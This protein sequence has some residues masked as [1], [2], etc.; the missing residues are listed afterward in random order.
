MARGE[1]YDVRAQ[2]LQALLEKVEEDQFPSSTML[3][4]IEQLLTPDDVPD[5]AEAL[6][7][8]IRTERYPSIPMMTRLTRLAQ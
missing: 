7:R 6:L 5:Y 8:R 3:D 2:M 1:S 4:W